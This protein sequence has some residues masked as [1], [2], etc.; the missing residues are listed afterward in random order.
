MYTCF[1]KSVLVFFDDKRMTSVLLLIWVSFSLILLRLLTENGE[2]LDF[3][4]LGPSETVKIMDI[5]INNWHKWF[6]VSIFTFCN[7]A[8]GEFVDS[9]LVPFFTNTIQDHKNV[10]IPY[11]KRTC[12]VIVQSFCLY[13]HIMS[14]FSIFLIFAQVDFLIV[15]ALADLMVT[16][17]STNVFVQR[18]IFDK[19]KYYQDS[20]PTAQD[21]AK[22]YQDCTP[23]AQDDASDTDETASTIRL[24]MTETV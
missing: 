14:I 4:R 22:Y 17:F 6:G 3:F 23:I 12:L 2:P 15:R 16:S 10:Y 20:T 21:T 13:V 7:T 18:K 11:S 8:V 1:N 9:A 19:E 5:K 24:V